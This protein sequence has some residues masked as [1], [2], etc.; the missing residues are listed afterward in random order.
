MSVLK[1]YWPAAAT[2]APSP[3]SSS[4]SHGFF[5]RGAELCVPWP[6]STVGGISLIPGTGL[7]DWIS[8]TISWYE[9]FGPAS[10]SEEVLV[11][12]EGDV[13]AGAA[14]SVVFGV[15]MI[16]CKPCE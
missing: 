7:P 2:P 11:W 3:L 10:G 16:S 9:S 8:S 15:G 6:S 5:L 13:H 4:L 12:A 1:T 14:G